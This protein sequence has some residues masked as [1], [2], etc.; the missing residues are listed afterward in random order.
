MMEI[1][2]V[3]WVTAERM[4]ELTGLT[5]RALVQIVAQER[6]PQNERSAG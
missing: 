3:E 1:V 2:Y 6:T 4:A 5:V